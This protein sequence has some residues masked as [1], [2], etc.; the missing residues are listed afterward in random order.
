[1]GWSFVDGIARFVGIPQQHDF[2]FEFGNLFSGGFE[3]GLDR[4]EYRVHLFQ[5]MLQM[6]YCHFQG[7]QAI[8]GVGNGQSKNFQTG[9]VRI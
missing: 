3:F 6:G 5:F 7:H 4:Q 9:G 8:G 2:S 1:M